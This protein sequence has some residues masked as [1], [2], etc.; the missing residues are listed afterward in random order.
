MWKHLGGMG[1]G[2]IPSIVVYPTDGVCF[3]GM[4]EHVMEPMVA[5]YNTL[6][7]MREPT[8]QM[9]EELHKMTNGR[10]A[11]IFLGEPVTHIPRSSPFVR[12]WSLLA[13]SS[14][15]GNARDENADP[16]PPRFLSL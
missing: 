4:I 14:V 12:L 8:A 7:P 5:V 2:D 1:K 9:G 10:S 3:G 13:V 16:P 15:L 11:S 6:R